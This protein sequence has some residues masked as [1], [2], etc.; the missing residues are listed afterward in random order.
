[1]CE[2]IFAGNK[3]IVLC[4]LFI[5]LSAIPGL[6]QT[7]DLKGLISAWG[8]GSFQKSSEPQLGIRFIPEFFIE[9][10]FSDNL[11]LDA[12]V[13]LNTYGVATFQ[14]NDD[15]RLE[16]DI[17]PYRLWA[18]FSSSQFEVRFGLQKIS[19]GSASLLRPLMWF[20]RLDPRDPLQ[21]TE[22]VYALL[23]RYYFVSNTNI[24]VWGLYGN[25]EPKGWE[26]F[27]S[28][29][30]TPEFG[31]RIQVPLFTGELAFSYN[32]RTA[33]I[34]RGPLEG[35]V[36]IDNLAQENRF[37]LDGKWDISVGIWIE[38]AIT[39]QESELLPYPWQRALNAGLDYTF[40]IGNGLYA[41]GEHLLLT[42]AR[43]TWGSGE[44][45]NFSCFLLRYPFSIMD[46]FTVI[47]Y[48]DWE[49]EEFYRFIN[50]QRTYDTWMFNIIGFWNPEEFLLYP[51]QAGNNPFVG[52]GFQIMVT[53]NF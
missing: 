26:A 24:W 31:G 3:K 43:E 12:T 42:Q 15:V 18:R 21:L 13:S 10:S 6:S 36:L 53:F 8:V 32:H 11:A 49:N 45:T 38:A 33:D 52:K 16:S 48:Y 35:L 30:K 39:H 40:D 47:L 17:A 5:S 28:D 14:Q 46:D 22:G 51:S 4:L 50:W 44:D 9:T 34:N 19:F 1:M 37:G 27:P 7:L 2:M 20:D 41:L 29:K 25:D 23:F